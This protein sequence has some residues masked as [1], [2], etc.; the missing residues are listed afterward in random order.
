[1]SPN[2]PNSLTVEVEILEGGCAPRR[3]RERDACFDLFS[4]VEKSISPGQTAKIACRIRLAIAEG[5]EGQIRGRS[6]LASKGVVIHP[7]TI[8]SEYRGEVCVIFHNFTPDLVYHIQPGD[9]IAQI[10]FSPVP[11]VVLRVVD[12]VD[13]DTERGQCGF[14]SS[15]R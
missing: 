1:M 2:R 11:D 13:Q 3:G 6:G 14:G 9:R 5:W 12:A 10:Q 4:G 8:D 15:G 7:G